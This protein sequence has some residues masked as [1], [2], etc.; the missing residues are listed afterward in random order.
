MFA[1]SAVVHLVCPRFDAERNATTPKPPAAGNATHAGKPLRLGLLFFN[2]SESAVL[3]HRA[4]HIVSRTLVLEP[5]N[6]S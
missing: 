5:F 3:A 2:G 6:F 4:I 1:A